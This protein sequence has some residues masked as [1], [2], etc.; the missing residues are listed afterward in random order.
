[1]Q[2][3]NCQACLL[4]SAKDPRFRRER[5]SFVI[6]SGSV[7]K[8]MLMWAL[9]VG[10]ATVGKRNGCKSLPTLAC[11]LGCFRNSFVSY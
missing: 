8:F 4:L 7:D 5:T 6:I 11:V 9:S 1:M 2:T 10:N 3:L